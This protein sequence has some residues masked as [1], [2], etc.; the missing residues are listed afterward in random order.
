MKKRPG[1]AQTL[2]IQFQPKC[3]N[4]QDA[5]R[6]ESFSTQEMEWAFF[7]GKDVIFQIDFSPTDKFFSLTSRRCYK[8]FLNEIQKIQIS[9]LTESTR[10]DYF[11]SNKQFWS[12]LEN[13]IVFTFQCR[14]RQQNI[15]AF[16]KKVLYHQLGVLFSFSGLKSITKSC[17]NNREQIDFHT[18]LISCSFNCTQ[19]RINF[20]AKRRQR[21]R[22]R[23]RVRLL[24]KPYIWRPFPK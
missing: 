2:K 15:G 4:F 9:H 16:S 10:I 21:R 19:Q 13:S 17:T 7:D 1:K 11:K 8:T 24:K 3:K 23:W 18:S 14:F 20:R 22:R 6:K 5:I 12:M